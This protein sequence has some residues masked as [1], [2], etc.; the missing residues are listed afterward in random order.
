MSQ[1]DEETIC[2]HC[3][4]PVEDGQAWHTL[5]EM[6]YDCYEEKFGRYVR[7]DPLP[8]PQPKYSMP[9]FEGL[10]QARANGGHLVHIVNGETGKALC[11]HAPKNDSH[12]MR[13]RGK[14]NFL[15]VG[16]TQPAGHGKYSGCRQCDALAPTPAAEASLDAV[17]ERCTGEPR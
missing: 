15:P 4:K 1:A 12:I 16:W 17:I 7:R 11:G 14:W 10:R 3:E 13:A 5:A 8:P 2:K 9:R 6:H